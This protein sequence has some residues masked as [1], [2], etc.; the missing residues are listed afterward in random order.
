MIVDAVPADGPAIRAIAARADVFTPEEVS[1]VG[2]LWEECQDPLAAS[3]SRRARQPAS[4][5]A[6]AGMCSRQPCCGS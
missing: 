2:E 3:I 6:S 5:S 4:V 1:C